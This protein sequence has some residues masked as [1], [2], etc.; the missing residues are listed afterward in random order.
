[1]IFFLKIEI[2]VY[3]KSTRQISISDIGLSLVRHMCTVAIVG[4]FVGKFEKLLSRLPG[5]F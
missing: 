2:F 4:I 3:I 5:E 1:M